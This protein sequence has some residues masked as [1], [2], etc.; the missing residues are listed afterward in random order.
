[1]DHQQRT[2]IRATVIIVI[3][4]A[5]AFTASF[6]IPYNVT[7]DARITQITGSAALVV[8]NR[9]PKPIAPDN[10][11]PV[12]LRIGDTLQLETGSTATIT[13]DLNSGRALVTGP[14]TL[15]LI[16]AHRHATT[17]GHIH[18]SGTYTLT[19]EQNGG[20]GRYFFDNA[21]PPVSESTITIW[22]NN[23]TSDTVELT[24]APCWIAE[25][26]PDGPANAAPITCP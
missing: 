3:L 26:P 25:A 21:D 15:R 5:L 14:A 9:V 1:M 12:R 6:A 22:I 10:P 13:F 17:Y 18:A 24:A 7:F 19:I 4:A 16:E 20:I 11:D 23:A 2:I 8:P